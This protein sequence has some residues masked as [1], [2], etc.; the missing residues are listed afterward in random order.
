MLCAPAQT[1]INARFVMPDDVAA[2]RPTSEVLE[3]PQAVSECDGLELQ[4]FTLRPPKGRQSAFD[5]RDER[6]ITFGKTREV[7]EGP[8]PDELLRMCNAL[9]ALRS[10]G[11]EDEEPRN[12]SSARAE[13]G[14]IGG[15]AANSRKAYMVRGA[16]S[17]RTIVIRRHL[18]CVREL[19]GG[20]S[21]CQSWHPRF[22]APVGVD[23]EGRR[24]NENCTDQTCPPEPVG[25]GR[26]P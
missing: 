22:R 11:R 17:A 25:S 14:K 2:R 16:C 9:V 15:A 12:D 19:D 3:L 1:S 5:P 4:R 21:D 24:D 20:I 8:S 6:R 18:S 26:E 10:A 23:A 7:V 13:C